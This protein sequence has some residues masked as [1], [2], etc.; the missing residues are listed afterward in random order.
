MT[1][2]PWAAWWPLIENARW[3]G[4]KG[5]AATFESMTALPWLTPAG[6]LPAVRAEVATVRYADG[7]HEFYALLVGYTDNP[8][9]EVI[10]HLDD[11]DLGAVAAVE[12]VADPASAAELR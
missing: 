2:A 12:A 7:R 8:T 11:P 9:T 1:D 5:L 10:L 6:A 3:F 4:G